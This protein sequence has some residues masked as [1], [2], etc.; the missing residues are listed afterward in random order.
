MINHIKAP[1]NKKEGGR[2]WKQPY[3]SND[4]EKIIKGREGGKQV[5]FV[6]F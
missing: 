3:K 5:L 1:N 2:G 6:T 4:S